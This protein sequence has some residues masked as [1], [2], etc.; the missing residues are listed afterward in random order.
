M[1]VSAEQMACYRKIYENK[2][3]LKVSKSKLGGGDGIDTFDK[4]SLLA[5]LETRDNMSE[6]LKTKMTNGW[7]WD[8]AVTFE[9]FTLFMCINYRFEYDGLSYDPDFGKIVRKLDQE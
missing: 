9:R 7:I 8:G 5:Y 3:Y 6:S 1:T 4:S 2:E